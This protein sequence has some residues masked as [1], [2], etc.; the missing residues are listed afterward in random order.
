MICVD[1][2]QCSRDLSYNNLNTPVPP[3][4]AKTFKYV[5][6]KTY[7]SFYISFSP[8]ENR[9]KNYNLFP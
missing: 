1:F 5:N 3:V 4:H 9:K 7:L 6:P 8:H 2:V